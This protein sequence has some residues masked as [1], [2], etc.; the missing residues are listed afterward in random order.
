MPIAMTHCNPQKNA[1]RVS[2]RIVYALRLQD[3]ARYMCYKYTCFF[4]IDG[5]RHPQFELIAWMLH[6][7]ICFSMHVLLVHQLSIHIFRR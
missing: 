4:E 7:I 1:L 3:C 2:L 6:V 5:T